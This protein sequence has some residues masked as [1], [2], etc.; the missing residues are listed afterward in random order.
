MGL[1]IV[2]LIKCKKKKSHFLYLNVGVVFLLTEGWYRFNI[3]LQQ[4]SDDIKP[5]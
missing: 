3:Y 2:L 4:S 5:K 1:T